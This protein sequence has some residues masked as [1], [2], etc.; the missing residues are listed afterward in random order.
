[1]IKQI[2]GLL[3]RFS[4]VSPLVLRIVVGII[5]TAHGCDK[6]WSCF[7]PGQAGYA[8]TVSQ[9]A[10][11]GIEPANIA[12]AMAGGGEFLGGLLVLMGLFTRI[13]ALLVAGTMVVAI[14]TVHLKGGLFAAD[15]GFEYPLTLLAAAISLMVTGGGSI[16]SIDSQMEA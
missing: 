9:F 6:L 2:N 10:A 13:G 15:G 11:L 5:M 1:M 7:H 8:V 3:G 12:A 16:L 14:A 4:Y